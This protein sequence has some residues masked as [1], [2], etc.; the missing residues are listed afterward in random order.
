M[1]R[2]LVAVGSALCTLALAASTLHAQQ[3]L[4]Q[5]SKDF[6]SVPRGTILSHQFKLTNQT[7]A[8]LH[9]AAV[10]TSC[11]CTTATVGKLELQPGESTTLMVNLDTRKFSG[12]RSFTVYLTLDR[13]FLEEIRV[14]LSATSRDDITLTPGQLNF[15]R[16]KRGSQAAAS[17]VVEQHAL[18]GWEIVGLENEN[19]YLLPKLTK[20][21][22]PGATPAYQLEVRL[23][24]DIPVG[25][26]HAD[27]YLKTNDP[28]NPR[29]RVPLVVEVEGNLV[30][31][32][33]ELVFGQCRQNSTNEKRVVLR[34]S[35]PF[36]I[37]R[38]EGADDLIS[39]SP[40]SSEAKNV[41]VLKVTFSPKAQ[42]GE[43][44]RRMKVFTDLNG[45][46]A[47]DFTVQATVVP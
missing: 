6:G 12:S 8:P 20:L 26:W 43:V 14:L 29:V 19:G 15:G 13:P 34:G 22:R 40:A 7:T 5:V 38:T 45:E 28:N 21:E 16:V 31:T 36:K 35:A 39:V 4:D 9:V 1:F 10:R 32:P 27:I 11:T 17:V 46:E 30:A 37:V 42:T 41:Q 44:I 3:L 2:H 23:R 18:S 47:A 33:G 24:D 25:A